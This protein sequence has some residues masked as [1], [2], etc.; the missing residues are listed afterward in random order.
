MNESHS[1]NSSQFIDKVYEICKGYNPDIEES[2]SFKEVLMQLTAMKDQA[3][4]MDIL[5]SSF[6]PELELFPVLKKARERQAAMRQ[7]QL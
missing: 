7:G 2:S 5:V 6:K 3:L 1:L 4:R